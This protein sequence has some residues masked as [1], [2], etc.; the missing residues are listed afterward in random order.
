MLLRYGDDQDDEFLWPKY[1]TMLDKCIGEKGGVS[2][3]T[4]LFLSL[5]SVVLFSEFVK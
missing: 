4:V 1:M 5:A 2:N 3:C